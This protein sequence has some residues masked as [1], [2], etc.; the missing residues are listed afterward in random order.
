MC[1]FVGTTENALVKEM[2]LK[3]E[4]RGPDGNRYW[5]NSDFAF[6]HAL[7][8]INGKTQYQPYRTK[9]GNIVLFNGEMYDAD[10][11]NDTKWLAEGIDTYGHKLLEACDWHGSIAWYKP[12]TN[13]LVLMRDH[14]GT[15]PLW[16][17]MEGR[18]FEFSTSLKSFLHKELRP[19]ANKEFHR[20]PQWFGNTTPYK[21]IQKVAP[22]EVIIYDTL[23]RKIKKKFNFWSYFN[24]KSESLNTA[25][26]RHKAIKSVKKVA[27]NINKTGLFLSGGM[28]STLILSL[29]KDVPELDLHVFSCG[30]STERGKHYTYKEMGDEAYMA[31]R[32]CKEYGIPLTVVNLDQASREHYS[33][34]WIANTHYTWSDKNRQA[35]RY[36]L[37]KTAAE[38]GCKVILTGDSGDELFTG[39]LHHAERFEKG[40][41]ERMTKDL[42]KRPWFPSRAFGEDHLSNSL[43]IDLLLTSEQ[44]IL[45]TDQTCGMFGM[46]SRIPFLTQSFVKYVLNIKGSIKFRQTKKFSRGTNKFL[47]REVMRQYLPEHVRNRINKTGWT[48]P[49]DNNVPVLRNQWLDHDLDFIETLSR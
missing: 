10:I 22:G 1:G 47:V 38:H 2:L 35:P 28:D 20:N 46:E 14:F 24:I 37:A 33:K 49:W 13:E 44:N 30:Y 48:S 11:Q 36:L 39:Y 26:F 21:N 43:F 8:D 5:Q 16:Y 6:G 41:P 12:N 34:M 29:L 9:K 19:N 3:Q 40:W 15:K 45:A 27:K 7:L 18:K 42:T 17:R 31:R 4:H 32:T 23:D 25:E